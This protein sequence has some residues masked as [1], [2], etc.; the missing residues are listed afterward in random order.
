MIIKSGPTQD[1]CTGR[2]F[3]SLLH[4]PR[5][6]PFAQAAVDAGGDHVADCAAELEGGFYASAR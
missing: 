6:Y 1:R 2:F 3:S 5:R 4:L